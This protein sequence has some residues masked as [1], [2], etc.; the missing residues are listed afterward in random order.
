MSKSR[1][2]QIQLDGHLAIMV[3]AN[4]KYDDNDESQALNLALSAREI[5]HNP[6]GSDSLI[7]KLQIKNSLY[8]LSTTTQYVPSKPEPYIGLLGEKKNPGDAK[9]VLLPL[10]ALEPEFM[11]KWHVFD[12]W[13]NEL[14]INDGDLSFSRKDIVLMTANQEGGIHLPGAV[15]EKYA[16]FNY[17]PARG[18]KFKVGEMEIPLSNHA[19]YATMRQIAFEILKSFEYYNNTKSYTRKAETN[20]NAIFFDDKVYFASYECEKYPLTAA[21]LVDP[22][23]SR[24]E[25]RGVFF[26]S[27]NFKDGS[28]NGR[29]LA[30]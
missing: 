23:M 28:K 25:K 20:L 19:V 4:Q 6:P 27:L 11:N 16:Q 26:D 3:V 5:F 12:D 2:L 7:N 21:A 17:D 15:D 10:S 29:I 14:V 13:W 22:R 30:I 24:I 8:L 18:W 1:E 9:A